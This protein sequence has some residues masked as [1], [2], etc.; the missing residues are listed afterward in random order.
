MPPSSAAPGRNDGS[1][2]DAG[3]PGV[4]AALWLSVVVLALSALWLLAAG[5]VVGAVSCATMA[6]IVGWG[7]LPGV[8][9]ADKR[10]TVTACAAVAA[11]AAATALWALYTAGVLVMAVLLSVA[12]AQIFV[13][14]RASRRAGPALRGKRL[15]R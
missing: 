3:D 6:A 1:T 2:V 8:A 13:V 5:G 9:R 7:A 15:Q 12:G 14:R 10:R 11:L 4:K